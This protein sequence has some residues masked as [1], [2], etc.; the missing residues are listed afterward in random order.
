MIRPR[1]GYIGFNR[2]SCIVAPSTVGGVW[3]MREQEA[4]TRSNAWLFSPQNILGLQLWLDFS[5]DSSI[6]LASNNISQINDLSGNGYHAT[7]ATAGDRPGTSTINGRPCGNW[8]TTESNKRLVYSSGGLNR[9]WREVAIVAVWDGTQTTFP[10]YNGLFTASSSSGT[11]SGVGLVGDITLATWFTAVTWRSN[12][13]L[14]NTATNTAFNT[15]KSPFVI[16]F[17]ASSNIG[18]DGYCIGQDRNETGFGNRGWV[19]RIGEIIA[20]NTELGALTRDRVRNYL[21]NKWGIV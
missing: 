14:N 18:V 16:Q 7:Q 6:T 4:F 8:G 19:G 11:A 15:I 12:L 3:T 21:V 5:N 20:Y 2:S 13:I 9:N 10:N 1:G 17:W